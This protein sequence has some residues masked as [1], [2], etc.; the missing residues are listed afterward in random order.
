MLNHTQRVVFAVGIVAVGG[1]FLFPPW[2]AVS[3]WAD[4]HIDTD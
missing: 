3:E 4:G 1:L 2:V